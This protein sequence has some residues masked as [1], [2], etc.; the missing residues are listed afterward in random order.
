MSDPATA[1]EA[2]DRGRVFRYIVN[3]L[4]ATA[5][6]FA[7][8]SFSLRVL[9]IGSAG[10]AN[11]GAAVIGITV[12]FLGSRYYVFRKREESIFSQAAKFATL[13]VSIACL[14]GLVLFAWTDLWRLDY[15]VGFLLATALQVLLSYWG[16]KLLVFNR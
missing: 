15:R 8:L 11:L 3:G 16:N 10:L 6:H 1:V 14:H 2:L 5:V 12:S 7:A 4:F 9:E 13:Y